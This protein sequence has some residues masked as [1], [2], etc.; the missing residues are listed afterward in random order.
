MFYPV[1]GLCAGH[2]AAEEG[3]GSLGE[4]VPMAQREGCVWTT[5]LLALVLSLRHTQ[6]RTHGER[7]AYCITSPATCPHDSVVGEFC[8]MTV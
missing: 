8:D 7:F 1:L 4:E 2:R 3:A 6:I 5:L